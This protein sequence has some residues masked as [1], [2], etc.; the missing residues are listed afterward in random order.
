MG[1][2]QKITT[3][4]K[5]FLENCEA[6]NAQKH[7]INFNGTC[8]D[9]IEIMLLSSNKNRLELEC[10]TKQYNIDFNTRI[11]EIIKMVTEYEQTINKGRL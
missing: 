6:L 1:E 10:Q 3:D 8:I 7:F 2:F 5:Q 4:N 11:D 9:E